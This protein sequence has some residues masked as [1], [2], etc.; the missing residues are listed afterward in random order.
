MSPFSMVLKGRHMK[1][2]LWDD[3][4]ERA[5]LVPHLLSV[6]FRTYGQLTKVTSCEGDA[7]IIELEYNTSRRFRAYRD[8]KL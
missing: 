3:S 7:V 6:F 8:V 5:S 4:V 2:D 1:T